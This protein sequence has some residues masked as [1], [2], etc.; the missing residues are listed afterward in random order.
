MPTVTS[1]SWAPSAL[2]CGAASP[3]TP[4]MLP[5]VA[6]AQLTSVNEVGLSAC[7]TSDG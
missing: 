3:C 2:N 1:R 4:V 7:A 5:V 6:P